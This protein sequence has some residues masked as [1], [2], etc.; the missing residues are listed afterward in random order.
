[1]IRFKQQTDNLY[2][3]YK[4]YL[5]IGHISVLKTFYEVSVCYY[6][7]TVLKSNKSLIMGLIKQSYESSRN[8]ME[9][10]KLNIPIRINGSLDMNLR[11]YETFKILE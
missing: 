11:K 5:L 3:I 9:A 8:S 6:D 4:D 7:F 10:E 1:M 2:K